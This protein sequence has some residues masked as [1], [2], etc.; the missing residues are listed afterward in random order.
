V[1]EELLVGPVAELLDKD[2]LVQQL[3]PLVV[4]NQQAVLVLQGVLVVPVQQVMA[5]FCRAVLGLIVQVWEVVADIMA[6][7]EAAVIAGLVPAK[8][9][10]V[11]QAISIQHIFPQLMLMKQVL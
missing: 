5:A 1:P 2:G 4:H 9:Q 6:A 10:P 7:A 11:V 3:I 8:E